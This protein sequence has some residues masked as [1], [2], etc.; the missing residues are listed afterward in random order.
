MHYCYKI[1]YSVPISLNIIVSEFFSLLFPQ[2]NGL[3]VK[4]IDPEAIGHCSVLA[5]PV[6]SALNG[7]L[8]AHLY[9]IKMT[10]HD[11]LIKIGNARSIIELLTK[12]CSSSANVIDT[13]LRSNSHFGGC[14]RLFM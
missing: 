3:F 2:T 1:I 11:R 7:S 12:I 5:P 8:S 4:N 14:E 9:D 10:D 6:V 13:E